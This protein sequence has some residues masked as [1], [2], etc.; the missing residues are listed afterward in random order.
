MDGKGHAER[1]HPI[2]GMSMRGSQAGSLIQQGQRPW[3]EEMTGD[4][5]GPV[6]S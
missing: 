2:M 4:E 6:G 5:L 1:Q 3:H